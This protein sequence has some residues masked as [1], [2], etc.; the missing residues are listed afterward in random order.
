MSYTP[1]FQQFGQYQ[2]YQQYQQQPFQAPAY[3]PPVL[4][5]QRQTLFG[6]TVSGIDEVSASDVPM[7]AVA[8]F[9]TTDGGKVYARAWN[10]DG[11]ITT[12]S[13]TRDDMPE[14]EAVPTIA[15]VM[16][17]LD[18]IKTLLS[19]VTAKPEKQPA[20]RTTKKEAA[21]E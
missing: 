17:Q 16:S 11:G 21:D 14:V 7:N 19:E 9:P 18:S 5:Q 20:R 4:N 6:R 3:Q 12:V 8:Y 10:G 1:G 2:P 13:Y 15:D